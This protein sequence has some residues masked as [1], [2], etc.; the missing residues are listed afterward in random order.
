MTFREVFPPGRVRPGGDHHGVA[1][2]PVTQDLADLDDHLST[3]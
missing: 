1:D 2:G 3:I